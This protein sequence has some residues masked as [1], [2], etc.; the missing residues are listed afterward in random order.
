MAGLS[1]STGDGVQLCMVN[2]DRG[3]LLQTLSNTQFCLNITVNYIY[4]VNNFVD[5]V[6]SYLKS[7][8]LSSIIAQFY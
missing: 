3:D 2:V 6:Q 4:T 1:R 8:F 5:I 7:I